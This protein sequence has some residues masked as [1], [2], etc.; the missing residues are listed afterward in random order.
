MLQ[1]TA[2]RYTMTK[3]FRFR[4]TKSFIS[5]TWAKS[6][7]ITLWNLRIFR[8]L[9][10]LLACLLLPIG[11]TWLTDRIRLLYFEKT[12]S[13]VDGGKP[14]LYRVGDVVACCRNSSSAAVGNLLENE[15]IGKIIH[16]LARPLTWGA[17]TTSKMDSCLIVEIILKEYNSC[18]HEAVLNA[19]VFLKYTITC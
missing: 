9:K 12:R 3:E 17:L 16:G 7:K 19:V 10:Y 4:Q 14:V 5:K 15:L 11:A 13:R 1:S 6:R 8:T 18:A 2:R